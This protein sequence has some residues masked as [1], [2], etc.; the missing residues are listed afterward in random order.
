MR[1]LYHHPM[2]SSSKAIRLL[3]GEYGIPHK[4]L[5]ESI[6]DRRP[7]FVDLG[8]CDELPVLVESGDIAITG[9]VAISE[10]V[11]ESLSSGVSSASLYPSNSPS[12]LR[13][14]SEMRRLITFSLWR[15]DSEI[16]SIFAH[17]RVVKHLMTQEQGGGPPDSEIIA[18]SS[19]SITDI[20]RL[21]C[22]F[23][24]A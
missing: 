14:R 10:Y 8:S 15:F 20:F 2:S 6:W 1:L 9:A 4:P 24:F 23:N 13:F 11:E 22:F 16:C 18:F 17:E 5:V 12:D 7:D 21:F 3:L 19:F